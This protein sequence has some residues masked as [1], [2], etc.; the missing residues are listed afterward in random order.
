MQFCIV[1]ELFASALTSHATAANPA[2]SQRVLIDFE[3]PQ[4]V[5]LAPNQADVERVPYRTGHALQI[6]TQA[7]ASWPGVLLQLP[8][9]AWNL[10]GFDG[11]EMDVH[12]PQDVPVRVLLSVNNPGA[13][14]RH[15]CNTESVNVP[16]KG[17]AVLVVPFGMWHGDPGHALDLSQIESMQVLLDRPGRGHRFV[18][19]N[20]RAVK[21]DGSRLK[22]I[23][24]DPFF[25]QM[26]PLLGR[27][28]NLGNALEAPREGEWG[29][30]IKDEYFDQIKRAGFDSV[31]LPVRWSAHA[32]TEAPYTIDP[33][34]FRRVDHVVS[35]ALDNGLAVVLNVHHYEELFEQ[36]DANSTRFV[37]LWRQI[38]DHYRGYSPALRFELLNEP[39]GKLTAE[40]WNKLLAEAL[41]EVRRSNPARD[42][43]IGPVGWNSI[44]ELSSLELPMDDRHLIVTVHYY[45]PFHFTHQGAEWASPEAKNW[46]G[47]KWNGTEA[48]KKAVRRDFDTA[49]AWAVEH[50][51]PVYLGEFGAYHKADLESRARWT[52]F[53][54]DE[55]RKRKMG[56]AYWEFCSGFGAY[57]AATGQWIESLRDVL[58]PARPK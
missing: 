27:G 1:A 8:R 41:A 12:N 25:Q 51:R 30:T 7:D 56:F 33:Q 21:F 16:A 47:T 6:V 29:V 35:K 48:E 45:S 20:I 44:Q 18:V 4:S 43:V 40:K 19:D 53:V 34:F 54:A 5:R 57:D 3:D 26:Q 32:G 38:A 36:P 11:V 55:A 17:R 2:P 42:V 14:G 52:R 50:K 46:V 58:L 24:A 28:I 10:T 9:G 39:N 49:I 37:A 22:E 23:M 15:H 31:R 13:D